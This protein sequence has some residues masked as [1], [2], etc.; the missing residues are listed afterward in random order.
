MRKIYKKLKLSKNTII[1]GSYA[2]YLQNK[3]NRDFHD[4]DI[5]ISSSHNIIDQNIAAY[6]FIIKNN[7]L[8]KKTNEFISTG[9]F[10][11]KN[12]TYDI[13]IMQYKNISEDMIIYYDGVPVLDALYITTFKINQIFT[14]YIK[15]SSNKIPINKA[16]QVF[17]DV[18]YLL[19]YFDNTEIVKVLT[20]CMLIN[21]PYDLYLYELNPYTLV[22]KYNFIKGIL[23]I[24]NT[25]RLDEF[26]QN[27]V[28]NASFLKNLYLINDIY[29]SFRAFYNFLKDKKFPNV[30]FYGTLIMIADKDVFQNII[31]I[32][33]EF[34]NIKEFDKIAYFKNNN[35]VIDM[36]E[37]VK[38]IQK[39]ILCNSKLF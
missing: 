32:F 10:R 8:V 24:T 13:D 15:F 21:L 23:R 2:L 17:Y 30:L 35:Y 11:I 1:H 9:N 16:Q 3:L 7:I 14:N 31:L 26:I 33:I 6:N 19:N 18:D 22:F 5:L 36:N 37:F 12:K 25:V 39:E 38:L 34:F 20:K 28:Q 29:F 4:I 27:L